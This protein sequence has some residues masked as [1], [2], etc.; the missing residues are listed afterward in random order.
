MQHID[1]CR[2]GLIAIAALVAALGWPA[3]SGAQT[4]RG[5]AKAVHAV[6]FSLLGGATTTVLS[7]TGTLGHAADARE[8]SQP[9]GNVSSLLSGTTLHATTIGWADQVASEAS[10][11]DLALNIAGLSIGADFVMARA[12]AAHGAAGAGSVSISNLTLNGLSLDVTGEP[13][14][15]VALPGARLVI[16]EQQSSASGMVVNALHVVIN[17]VADVVIAS[18][19]AGIQ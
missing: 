17:G 7:D 5:Q 3:Q 4:V 10:L 8:A 15:Q 9:A 14:Q 11:A 6:T 16:N 1:P 2:S 19:T 12:K 18:A 13:N